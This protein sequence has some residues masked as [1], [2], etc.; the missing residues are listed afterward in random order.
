MAK[1]SKVFSV[2]VVGDDPETLMEKYDENLKVD[3]YIKYTYQSAKRLR[4]NAIKLA[5]EIIN[6]KDKFQLTS[7]HVDYFREKANTLKNMSDFEY[8]SE[9]TQGLYIDENGDAWSTENKEGKYQTCKKGKN[10]SLPFLTIDGKE[11]NSELKKNVKWDEMHM[12]PNTV[13]VYERTWDMVHGKYEPSTPN[14]QKIYDNM[15]NM[16]EYF[17][18]FKDK[19]EYVIHNCAYWNYAIVDKNGWHDIDEAKSPIEWVATF[20]PIFIEPLDDNTKLTIY[21]CTK[22]K[23]E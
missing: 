16:T 4:E 1:G 14:E 7:Y 3:K 23:E 5:E 9:L 8:Y 18:K 22:G 13:V 21:E 12:N 19:K 11:S 20:Y 17:S 10:F 15:K 6:N 2:L